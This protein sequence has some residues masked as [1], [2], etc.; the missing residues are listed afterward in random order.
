MENALPR[1]LDRLFTQ[2]EDMAVGCHNL[3]ATLNI[4]QNKEADVRADLS[5]ALAADNTYQAA[6]TTRIMA[7]AAQGT[8]DDD[9][10]AFIMAARDV[11]KMH[12]GNVWSLMWAEVGFVNGKLSVPPTLPERQGLLMSLKMYFAANPG[13]E[14]DQ[15]GVTG[16][17]ADTKFIGLSTTR[18]AVN[19]ARGDMAVKK[20][21]RDTAVRALRTRMRGLITELTQLLPG[22]DGRWRAFGLNPPNAVGLPDMPE[23]LVVS[24]GAPQHLL[25]E[26][27]SAALA[28]RYRL[29]RKIVGVDSDFVLVK[30][31]TETEADLNTFTSGQVVRIRVSAVDDAG[32]SL[33]S[34]PVEQ[35]VP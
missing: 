5:A 16:S 24:G 13:R 28:D 12:L 35:T 34:E 30:T 7:V 32:E 15:I 25:A 1:Q 27:E 4:K 31:V 10:R 2:G 29:Y 22:D 33:L 20:E 14:A 26:W 19:A 9:A 11:L 3:E 21:A 6:K 17:A 8:A 23:G 18:T